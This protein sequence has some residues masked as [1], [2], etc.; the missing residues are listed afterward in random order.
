[1]IL[2]AL[3]DL[4]LRRENE[5]PPEG[6]EEKAIPFLIVLDR[7][8]RFIGLQDTRSPQ[9][10]KLIARKFRVP[11]EN[12]RSGKNA[13]QITNLLWD[14]Y[15]YVLEW[16]KS[17]SQKDK[18]MARNQHETFRRNIEAISKNLPKDAGIAAVRNFL[19]SDQKERVLRDPL[20]NECKKIPGC[21]LSFRLDDELDLICQSDD[22]REYA[23]GLSIAD[24]GESD[25]PA[26]ANFEGICLITGR[27]ARIARLHPRTPIAGAKSNAKIVSFQKGMGFDSYGKEQKWL[28]FL[29]HV[30]SW[31]MS[32]SI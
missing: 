25:L 28:F 12:E 11:K 2:R 26:S 23:A 24:D 5:F 30:L 1:M 31:T 16:P 27:K 17:D 21:I 29:S 18:E 4:C 6:F 15:G 8:G 32:C 22:L 3:H 7:E 13:W 9:G 19:N 14:H 10:K 20:W